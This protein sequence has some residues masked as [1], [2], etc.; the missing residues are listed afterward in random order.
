MTNNHSKKK[1]IALLSN[2]PGINVEYNKD[3]G[4][5]LKMSA[6]QAYRYVLCTQSSYV[7]DEYNQQYI[8]K[9][10]ATF[11]HRKSNLENGL[12][13]INNKTRLIE[14]IEINNILTK[15]K[16]IFKD[17]K[18]VILIEGKMDPKIL[19]KT[20]FLLK[21]KYENLS[22]FIISFVDPYGSE[23]EQYY[24]YIISE[25]FINEGMITDTQIPW[26]YRG[27]PDVSINDHPI[28]KTI[29]G[30]L[31]TELSAIKYFLKSKINLDKINDNQYNSLEIIEVKTSAKKSQINK[32]KN[33]GVANSG[34]EL[35][36]SSKSNNNNKEN[37]L[38][39][40]EKNVP[41]IFKGNNYFLNK[42]AS[43][44][45]KKWFNTYLKVHLIANLKL[46][47]INSLLLKKTSHKKLMSDALINLLEKLTFKEILEKIN[48][49]L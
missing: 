29:K 2:I 39:I 45:D 26:E 33:L 15:N 31:I 24:E 34:Y 35:L 48:N 22:N 21:D 40:F 10:L 1:L 25:H 16:N 23:W 4:D 28:T 13:Q 18:N 3:F 20:Y 36:A 32:F 27:T 44:N 7:T 42:Q 12:F 43:V 6:R 8:K 9:I 37:G 41:K 30:F 46:S 47:E 49:G 5:V 17:N 38:I 19:S 14:E 11:N